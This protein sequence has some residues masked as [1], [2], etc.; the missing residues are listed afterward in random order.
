MEPAG[1]VRERDVLADYA[2][3]L[4]QLVDLSGIRRCASWSTR[5][6]AWGA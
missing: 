5:A 4:R 3:Y 2:G 6:T 1:Q